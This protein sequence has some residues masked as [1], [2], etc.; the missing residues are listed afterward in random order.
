MIVIKLC[1]DTN[2][3]IDVYNDDMFDNFPKIPTYFST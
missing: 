2:F 1:S 3:I